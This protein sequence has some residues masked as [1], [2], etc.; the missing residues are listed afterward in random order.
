M[1]PHDAP[2]PPP[3]TPLFTLALEVRRCRFELRLND[4]PVLSYDVS[5]T[6]I[7]TELPL[8]QSLLTGDNVLTMSLSAGRLGNGDPALLSRPGAACVAEVTIRPMSAPDGARRR[9][10]GLAFEGQRFQSLDPAVD[11]PSIV[12]PGPM[13]VLA[14]TETQALGRVAFALQTPF[15]PWLWSRAERLTLDEPTAAELLDQYR[16]F[17]AAVD[18]RDLAALRAATHENAR[19]IQSAF[20]LGSL[21]EAHQMLELEDTLRRNGTVVEPLELDL[22]ME[23][24]AD[25][26]VARLVARDGRSPVRVSDPEIEATMAFN[27]LYCRVPGRGWVQIR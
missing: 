27:L 9:L 14:E 18:R 23:L 20:F 12:T 26:R 5:D 16:Q 7:S 8:N 15:Q 3:A 19:E 4:L 13:A 21:N 6:E 11:A 24:L 17:W 1:P 2:L 25:G 22:R 10:A